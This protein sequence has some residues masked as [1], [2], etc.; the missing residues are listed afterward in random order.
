MTDNPYE[1]PRI[2]ENVV[3]KRDARSAVEFRVRLAVATFAGAFAGFVAGSRV[4]HVPFTFG[5]HKIEDALISGCI[6]L[7]A[8][9]AFTFTFALHRERRPEAGSD[10]EPSLARRAG[11]CVGRVVRHM[12]ISRK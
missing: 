6:L 3:P 2:T 10:N 11:R 1:T 4:F 7:G 9:A 12:R 5:N 8:V